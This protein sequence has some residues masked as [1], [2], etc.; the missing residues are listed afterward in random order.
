MLKNVIKILKKNKDS[1][2]ILERGK[3][4]LLSDNCDGRSHIFE[5]PT[6]MFEFLLKSKFLTDN[7]YAGFKSLRIF[8]R[9]EFVCK[10]KTK[11][12]K[13]IESLYNKELVSKY[14]KL[15]NKLKLLNKMNKSELISSSKIET[16]ENLKAIDKGVALVCRN[17]CLNLDIKNIN[18][19]LIDER[20][21]KKSF[22]SGIEREI[23]VV[24]SII[25][26]NDYSENLYCSSYNRAQ[27]PMNIEN[28][29]R[30]ILSF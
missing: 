27:L 20:Y 22:L 7:K 2:V 26:S 5:I 21:S 25:S 3:T 8:D 1:G 19:N 23:S 6:T 28:K 10:V 11:D 16:L 13:E 12:I 29:I 15:K 9:N 24:E 14:L 4:F 17:R 30:S 18:V